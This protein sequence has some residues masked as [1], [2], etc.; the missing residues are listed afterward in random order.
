MK[1]IRM[2]PNI[3]KHDMET[4]IRQTIQFL[5]KG[6]QVRA[7]IFFKGRM[8]VFV[9]RGKATLLEFLSAISDYG[10]VHGDFK[11]AGKRMQVMINPKKH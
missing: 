8:I 4:K 1:E 10:I 11:M 5:Q 7:S 3:G 6:Y 9:D 2:T